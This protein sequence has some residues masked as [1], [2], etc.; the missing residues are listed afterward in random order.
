MTDSDEITNAQRADRVDKM[1]V[2]YGVL[3]GDFDN[4]KDAVTLSCIIADIKHWCAIHDVEFECALKIAQ[5]HYDE[6]INDII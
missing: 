2:Y 6:E 1:L 4:T 5:D 3:Q